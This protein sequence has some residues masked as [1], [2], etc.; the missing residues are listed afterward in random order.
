MDQRELTE[1]QIFAPFLSLQVSDI[2]VLIKQTKKKIK[3]KRMAIREL[4]LYSC[5]HY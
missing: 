4:T 3:H 5:F 1:V 2:C